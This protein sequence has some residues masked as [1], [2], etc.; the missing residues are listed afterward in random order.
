VV[1]PV[2]FIVSGKKDIAGAME[3]SAFA[4]C[5]N[6]RGIEAKADA[7]HVNADAR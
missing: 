4:M 1:T 6:A 2:Y 7:V 5:V 3:V